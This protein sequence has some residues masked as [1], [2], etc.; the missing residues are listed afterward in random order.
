MDVSILSIGSDKVIFPIKFNYYLDYSYL[1]M[2]N[3]RNLRYRNG[4]QI[5][6]I[7]E[8]CMDPFV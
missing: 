2:V 1:R 5:F 8:Y 4:V 3:K 7:Y 6:F